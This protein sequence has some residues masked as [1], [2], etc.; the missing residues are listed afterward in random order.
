MKELIPVV[1]GTIIGSMIL[2]FSI[3]Y[4]S[5]SITGEPQATPEQLYLWD[6][7]RTD[8][9]NSIPERLT[10]GRIRPYGIIEPPYR[11]YSYW[12]EQY[13]KGRSAGQ[14]GSYFKW[15]DDCTEDWSEEDRERHQ[16]EIERWMQAIL[17]RPF[18]VDNIANSQE[19]ERRYLH[20]LNV[21]SEKY[22]YGGYGQNKYDYSIPFDKWIINPQSYRNNCMTFTDKVVFGWSALMKKNNRNASGSSLYSNEYIMPDYSSSEELLK[23]NPQLLPP[24]S[25]NHGFKFTRKQSNQ[26][27]KRGYNYGWDTGYQD[28][29]DAY[30]AWASYNDF[31]KGGDYLEGYTSGYIDGY[32]SG[33]NDRDDEEEIEEL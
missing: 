26:D 1:L 13:K 23:E 15:L 28:A 5:Y 12:Q 11:E 17:N 18:D 3:G 29:I 4:V 20:N 33:K 2:F 27:W 10:N 25:N 32:E 6:R 8:A 30:G 22:Y 7:I 9:S 24:P 31:G 16:K 14:Y 21:I 19:I